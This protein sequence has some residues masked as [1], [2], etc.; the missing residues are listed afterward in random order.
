LA[1][2]GVEATTTRSGPFR[3]DT[4]SVFELRHFNGIDLGT[5]P[6]QNIVEP[7]AVAPSRPCT[8]PRKTGAPIASEAAAYWENLAD[9]LV[10]L[11]LLAQRGNSWVSAFPQ[12]QAK[13]G[14]ADQAP[15]HRA[16]IL[17]GD[18]P[19]SEGMRD[20]AKNRRQS[21]EH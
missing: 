1:C 11:V 4:F 13:C 2:A 21:I 8:F 3:A 17:G 9:L 10:R 15:S 7:H 12:F 5:I 6:A 16:N 20:V 19:P 14:I 18:Q